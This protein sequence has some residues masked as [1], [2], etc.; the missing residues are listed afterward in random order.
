MMIAGMIEVTW[1]HRGVR[2]DHGSPRG[3][4]YRRLVTS[5]ELVRRIAARLDGMATQPSIGGVQTT[6]EER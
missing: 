2:F 1:S 4:E 6:D 5:E 3:L